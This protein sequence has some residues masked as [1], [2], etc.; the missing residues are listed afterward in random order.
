AQHIGRID[1]QGDHSTVDL[2]AGMPPEVM[3]D[4]RKA[5]VCGQRLNIRRDGEDDRD[6]GG[7]RP[8]RKKFGG[9]AK[10]RDDGPTRKPHKHKQRKD[11]DKGKP[12]R[13]KKAGKPDAG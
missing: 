11:K 3:A 7:D 6:A 2:P 5:W 10:H 9:H 12:K 4:L 8:P 13:F 1:I